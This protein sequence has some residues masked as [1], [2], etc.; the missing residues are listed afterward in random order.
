MF[1]K[2]HIMKGDSTDGVPNIL[3]SDNCFVVGDRQRPLTAKKIEQYMKVKPTELETSIA[4]NY[5]RNEQLIDLSHTPEEIRTKVM[6][7]YNAQSNKDR[8]KLMNYFIANKLRNLTEH[9]GDF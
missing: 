1:L 3:S 4:R 7:S 9:I 8:S 2:E 6:E 5:F